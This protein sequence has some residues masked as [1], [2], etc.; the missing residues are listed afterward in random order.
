MHN[1]SSYCGLVDAKIRVS[2][3]DLPVFDDLGMIFFLKGEIN[4]LDTYLYIQCAKYREY[5]CR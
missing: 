5:Q 1:L 2:E 4:Q 3:K